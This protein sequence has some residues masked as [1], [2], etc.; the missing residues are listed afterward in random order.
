MYVKR[1]WRQIVWQPS[2]QFEVGR[3]SIWHKGEDIDIKGW[4][5]TLGLPFQA[6]H[7]LFTLEIWYDS[8]HLLQPFPLRYAASESIPGSTHPIHSWDTICD[9]IWLIITHTY[10]CRYRT[11]TILM[12]SSST[13][14]AQVRSGWMGCLD[15]IPAQIAP[16]CVRRSAAGGVTN[17]AHLKKI[18]DSCSHRQSHCYKFLP[19]PVWIM[20]YQDSWTQINNVW[21]IDHSSNI[22]SC[23]LL[24]F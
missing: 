20:S 2:H 13:I 24:T 1:V 12:T 10:R 23:N 5:P 18:S 14:S 3:S 22:D 17:N 21:N 16:A 7:N 11:H 15:T 4:R 9:M 6:Q 8:W 19:Y